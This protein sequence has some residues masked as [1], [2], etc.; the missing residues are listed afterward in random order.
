MHISNTP[1]LPFKKEREVNLMLFTEEQLRIDAN[2]FSILDQAVYLTE[3]ESTLQ[4]QMI[5]VVE[6]NRLQSYIIDFN[7]IRQLS[8]STG[9]NYLDAA[10]LVAEQD[11]IALDQA[12]IAIDEADLIEDPELANLGSIVVRPL[13]E[14]DD[15]FQFCLETVSVFIETEDEEFLDLLS[16][17]ANYEAYDQHFD[18]LTDLL[19]KHANRDISL[20]QTYKISAAFNRMLLYLQKKYGLPVNDVTLQDYKDNLA[21][22][23]ELKELEALQKEEAKESST[24]IGSKIGSAIGSITGSSS[25]TGNPESKPKQEPTKPENTGWGFGI[26]AGIGAG[27]ASAIGGGILA[28]RHYRDK[29]KTV[30]AKRIAALRNIY[31]KFMLRAQKAPNEGIKNRLKRVAAK[32]LQ[33]IDKL[34][35]FLQRKADGR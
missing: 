22:Y 26:K 1:P 10:V 31:S 4:P 8:E 15:E 33:V 24:S 12:C 20:K 14:L 25:N 30:I 23:K 35:A 32:I 9:L 7:G 29:P 5:P 2:P 18:K 17:E 16:E 11:G 34:L 28:Y 6:N 19:I 27:I 3:D 21:K 13:S